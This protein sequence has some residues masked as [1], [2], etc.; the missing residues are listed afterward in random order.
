M[1]I[2]SLIKATWPIIEHTGEAVFRSTYVNGILV[3][4]PNKKNYFTGDT[5]LQKLL[6]KQKF[7]WLT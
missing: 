2:V 3:N 6:I 7:N 1:K 5:V 4:K